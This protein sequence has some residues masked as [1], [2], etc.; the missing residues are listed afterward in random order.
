MADPASRD[1]FGSIGV[2]LQRPVLVVLV[3]GFASGLPLLL[4]ISTL[5]V[6]L[7]EAGVSKTEIGLFAL[8][9]APYTL[10]F[11]WAPLMDRMPLPPLT[12]WLGRRRGWMI[13]TQLG[14]MAAVA[15]LGATDPLTNPLVTA[16]FA[17]A[18][19]FCSASQDVVIDAYRV[20][21]LDESQQGAG[22]AVIV[23]G[24]RIGMLVSGAGALFL[25]E[26][27]SWFAVY[28]AMAGFVS[29]G[30]IMI[31]LAP[32]PEGSRFEPIPGNSRVEKTVFWLRGA[33]I[34]PFSDFMTRRGWLLILVFI[35][36]YKLGDAF[37]SVMTNPFYLELGFTKS[38][39][40]E[41]TKVFGL[42]AVL[43]GAFIGGAMVSRFNLLWVL[44][45]CGILQ[46]ASNLVFIW[47][48]HV[49]HDVG[50]LMVS[51]SVENI[52]GGMGT[53]AFV[54]YLSSL[55]NV[56]FTATQYALLSSFMGFGRTF[57]ASSSGWFADN[58]TWPE[59]FA[60][61]ALIAVPGL[62]LLMWL[63]KLYPPERANDRSG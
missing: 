8:V 6:W 23:F 42:I 4:T 46:G 22:A 39:I 60:I 47:Q 30:M 33:V 7:K 45:V 63:M 16:A 51:I 57:F 34:S 3:L 15:G 37:M 54:A 9:G 35:L 52:T 29:V 12:N 28:L 5:S 17:L 48:A 13:A 31:L 1:W 2:Y 36:I 50:W 58:F 19:T 41:V 14:L 49:G 32:E 56:A 55:T 26:V 27:W 62:L 25:A 61:S 20:E 43:V 40:A 38:E 21:S 24:Y 10:K 44:M 53:A 18:V 11:L 59:F